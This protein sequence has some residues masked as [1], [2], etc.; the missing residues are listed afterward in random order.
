MDKPKIYSR[1]WRLNHLYKIIDKKGEEVRFK[2]NP[3][4]IILYTKEQELRKKVGKVWLAIL[5]ARQIWFTTYKIIDKLDKCLFYRNVTANIVAHS[6]EKLEDI[7]MRVKFAYESMPNLIHLSDWTIRRKPIPKY[8]NKSAYFFPSQN[9]Y[10]KV[11][12]D[13]RSWTNTD[14]HVSEWAFIDDFTWMMRATIPASENAD[15][16]IETTANWMNDFKW[17][18]DN[19]TRFE[20][21]FIPRFTDLSYQKQAPEWYKCMQE[22]KYIQDRYN[23]SDN[24]MYWYEEK[25]KN[26]RD[27]TLQEYPSEPIDAFISSGNPFYNLQHIKEYPIIEWVIDEYNK[28]IIWYNKTKNNDCIIWIDFAEWLDHWDYTVIRIRDRKLKLIA[29]YRWKIEPWEVC[30]LIEFFWNNWI[31]GI[32]W[33]ERNNH[34]HTFLYAA[35]QYKRYNYIYQPK[36]DKNDKDKKKDGQRWWLTNMVTRPL[37]LDEHKDAINNNLLQMDKQLKDE[38][39]TFINKNWKPQADENCNDDVVM[40]DAICLQMLK[41]PKK[42][43]TKST[44]IF[45]VSYDSVLY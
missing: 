16:T 40:A 42:D 31:K 11:T 5:K 12:L 36:Q 32:I 10:F 34:W 8:D 13:S 18:W 44:E 19:D 3:W 35:K 23:L 6:R 27:G 39:N 45:T 17:F 7:F 26:D 43:N 9:S 2:L 29:T 14:L 21:V 41:E 28:D 30:R 20:K 4:Q 24:Q 15:I 25:Y 38:C 1:L 33:P 22:L 37:M